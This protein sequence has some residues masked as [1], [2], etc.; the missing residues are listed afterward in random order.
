V[1]DPPRKFVTLEAEAERL[2]ISQRTLRR[3]IAR[4]ELTA[5]R[6]GGR[7]IRLDR[8]EVDS[9]VRKIPTGAA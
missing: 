8:G 1:S 6:V 5:Y 4:G 2:A 3:M 7:L 9:L